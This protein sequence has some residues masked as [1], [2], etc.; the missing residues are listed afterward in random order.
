MIF[1]PA[2]GQSLPDPVIRMIRA[3]GET[4]DARLLSSVAELARQAHP[5]LVPQVDSL[6]AELGGAPK[7]AP[8]APVVVATLP[9]PPP[10]PPAP[11]WK[12]EVRAGGA[13]TTGNND[14]LGANLGLSL[15]RETAIWRNE[16]KASADYSREN[17]VVSR[18]RY[19][20]GYQL[21]RRFGERGYTLG[22]LGWEQDHVAGFDRR[23][24]EALGLGYSAIDRTDIDL[25][26]EGGP[27]WRQTWLVDGSQDRTFAFRAALKAAWRPRDGVV[28][29]NDT[30]SYVQDDNSTLT[31]TT[32][33][34]FKLIGNLATQASVLVKH[35]TSPP[36]PLDKTDTTTRLSV[37]Y[38]F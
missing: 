10:P 29:S 22:V 13:V 1:G 9:E 37:V 7:E 15:A 16:L 26:L 28:L 3:A 8:P 23:F 20:A 27:G 25:D 36:I 17:G 35:E 11:R 14:S 18:E 34:T 32:S 38:A 21:N 6:V 31:S 19:M 4:G 12:G 30:S 33:L 2:M 5:E 24:S